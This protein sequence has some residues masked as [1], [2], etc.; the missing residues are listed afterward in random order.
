MQS[1]PIVHFELQNRLQLPEQL[2]DHLSVMYSCLY[3]SWYF[4]RKQ[5]KK[6]DYLNHHMSHSL[7]MQ[8]WFPSFTLTISYA[9]TANISHFY[10]CLSF[11]CG[12]AVR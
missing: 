5:Y 11:L 6:D 3:F 12:V 7:V 1:L 2:V 8:T 4:I 9:V 10:K